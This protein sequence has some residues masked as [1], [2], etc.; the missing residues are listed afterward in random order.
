MVTGEMKVLLKL[1]ISIL[2]C[3]GSIIHILA[4]NVMFPRQCIRFHFI[5]I[6]NGIISILISRKS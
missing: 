6:P 5:N 3:A 2:N 4:A 1:S